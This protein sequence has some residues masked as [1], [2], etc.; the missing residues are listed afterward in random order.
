LGRSAIEFG[1]PGGCRRDELKQK[2]AA[3][4]VTKQF[5]VLTALRQGWYHIAD[6][7]LVADKRKTRMLTRS[8]KIQPPIEMP[9]FLILEGDTNP[10]T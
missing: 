5:L 7:D 3:L 8:N 4:R 9:L 6:A 1:L 2:A 10:K